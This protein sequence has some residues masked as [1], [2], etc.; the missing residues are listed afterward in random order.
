[1]SGCARRYRQAGRPIRAAV[2]AP[3]ALI[4]GGETTVTVRG[5]GRGGRNAEFLLSLGVALD[6]R[7]G[8]RQSPPTPT[9]STA[10][11]TMPAPSCCP[12]LS[13]ARLRAGLNA[14]AHLADNDAYPLL[15]S[16]AIWWSPVPPA[17]MSTISEPFLIDGRL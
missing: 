7:P 1:M 8:L 5:G 11:K 12:I 17:P 4:S 15:P 14:K 3:C 13:I 6:G 9:V 2:K 10:A 16:S